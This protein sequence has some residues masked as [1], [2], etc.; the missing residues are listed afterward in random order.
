M[1][2]IKCVVVGDDGVGKT[3][4]LI[5]YTTNAFPVE[6]IPDVFDNYSANVMV[7]GKPINLGLWDTAGKEDYDR[8]RPLAYPQTDIFIICFSIDDQESLFN[9]KTKWYP[10]LMHH[11]PCTPI[12]L[13][14]T[15]CDLYSDSAPTILQSDEKEEKKSFDPLQIS[16][17]TYYGGII[18]AI[19]NEQIIEYKLLQYTKTKICC[20]SKKHSK[21]QDDPHSQNS[22]ILLNRIKYNISLYSN[23]K[24]REYNTYRLLIDNK[25]GICYRYKHNL[26]LAMFI[27]KNDFVQHSF[28][29]TKTIKRM[30]EEIFIHFTKIN[31]MPLYIFRIRC[32]NVINKYFTSLSFESDKTYNYEQQKW[33]RQTISNKATFPN[34]GNGMI[35]QNE[36]LSIGNEICAKKIIM[37]SA[38]TTEGVK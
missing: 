9:V 27:N 19:N 32:S 29:I 25:W 18:I 38:L 15:K 8:L 3:C 12:I 17:N 36:M 22:N 21:L 13:C 24:S 2:N 7:D 6:Y 26:T 5:Q 28:M 37:C 4:L 23:K 11:C 14:A 35:S 1:Q 10:E 30:F 34:Q 33:N 20:C 16:S 31:T